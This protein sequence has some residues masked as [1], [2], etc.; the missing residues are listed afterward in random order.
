MGGAG[1]HILDGREIAGARL[2]L[3]R[4]ERVAGEA[5]A[6]LTIKICPCRPDT[7]I[8]LQPESVRRSRSS[9]CE[10]RPLGQRLPTPLEPPLAVSLGSVKIPAPSENAA[11]SPHGKTS[12]RPGAH[13]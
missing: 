5:I 12:V 13:K 4:N 8:G 1:C 6:E 3:H 11:I 10:S 7:A 9:T 2:G